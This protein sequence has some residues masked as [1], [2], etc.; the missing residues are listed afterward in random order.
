MTFMSKDA[1][2]VSQYSMYLSENIWTFHFI[3]YSFQKQSAEI[4]VIKNVI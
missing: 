3:A 2:V 4:S 1:Y